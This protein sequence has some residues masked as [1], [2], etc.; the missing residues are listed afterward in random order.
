MIKTKPKKKVLKR[1]NP[2]VQSKAHLEN[3]RRDLEEYVTEQMKF[4]EKDYNRI[5]MSVLQEVQLNLRSK[6]VPS[7]DRYNG[8]KALKQIFSNLEHIAKEY[9]P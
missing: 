7:E 1:R 3:L 9:A 2:V 6:N 5:I 4:L 8:F